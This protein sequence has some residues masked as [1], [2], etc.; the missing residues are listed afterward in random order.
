[1]ELGTIFGL[2]SG[3]GPNITLIVLLIAIGVGMGILIVT[4]RNLGSAIKSQGE[5][6]SSAMQKEQERSDRQDD[7]IKE[8]LQ[9][10]D[11]RITYI[12]TR[13]ATKED[14][15]SVTSGWK[16]E[17]IQLNQR[18]DRIRDGKKEFA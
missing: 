3:L 2:A 13:Y 18:I 10:Q 14:L 4:V 6:F 17:Y 7:W 5:A 9:K 1:M 15:Y 8:L 12:E 11:I 16:Q